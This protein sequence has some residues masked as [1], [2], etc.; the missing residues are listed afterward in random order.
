MSNSEVRLRLMKA[1]V[2][3]TFSYYAPAKKET[4]ETIRRQSEKV[5]RFL[6]AGNILNLIPDMVLVL[7]SCRQA[8]YANL[9]LRKAINLKNTR[10]FLGKRPGDLL[11]CIC[12]SPAGNDCGSTKF[13]RHCG[14][15]NS[16]LSALEQHAEA[17]ECRITNQELQTQSYMVWTYPLKIKREKFVIFTLRDRQEFTFRNQ[18]ALD[19]LSNLLNLGSN[20][21]AVLDFYRDNSASLSENLTKLLHHQRHEINDLKELIELE[22][23]ACKP[24][25]E[26]VNSHD[27]LNAVK[28]AAEH[29][30]SRFQLK[31]HPEMENFPL[32]TDPRLLIKAI[33]FLIRLMIGPDQISHFQLQAV[34]DGKD[35]CF[36]ICSDYCLPLEIHHS[37]TSSLHQSLE[38]REGLTVHCCKL[39][40]EFYLHG[41][42]E[43]TVDPDSGTTVTIRLTSDDDNG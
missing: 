31:T 27:I 19:F 36:Q 40:L 17:S 24:I 20:M 34:L 11:H 41:R 15:V 13:C 42:I 26:H 25:P 7:N 4:P 43:T 23:N 38:Q 6:A 32:T 33:L 2:P 14:A 9:S 35:A 10:R 37:L 5:K 1:K 28:T 8:V 16:I 21:E 12:L 18:I 22:S 30:I 29:D 3:V 39:I